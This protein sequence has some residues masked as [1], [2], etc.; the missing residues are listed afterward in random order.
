MPS[1]DFPAV[2]DLGQVTVVAPTH[3][4]DVGDRVVTAAERVPVV[5]LEPLARRASS[6]LFVLVAA[7]ASVPLVHGSLHRGRDLARRGGGLALRERLPRRLGPGET[8]GF[9]PLELLGDGLLDDRGQVAVGHRG[10]HEGPQSHELVVELG[11][12]R[13]LDPV[14]AWG[15]R[16]NPRG[17]RRAGG[18]GRAGSARTQIRA[19]GHS[20][21]TESGLTRPT[22]LKRSSGSARQLR[23]DGVGDR[24]KHLPPDAER[25]NQRPGRVGGPATSSRPGGRAASASPPEHPDG[26]NLRHEL[27]D[28]SLRAVGGPL[29]DVLPVR[30]GQ[31]RR[32]LCDG[33]QVQPP[34]GQQGQEEGMLSRGA[35]GGDPE[36]GLGLGEIGRRSATSRD[37]V[38][39]AP[40]GEPSLEEARRGGD[41]RGLSACRTRVLSRRSATARGGAAE[42]CQGE[43]ARRARR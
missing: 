18:R 8:P 42:T 12:G 4:G 2:V 26:A 33:R 16:R 30:Q 32:Q 15:Q 11:G 13:E 25:G 34:V 21:R 14:A 36:V 17:P 41:A 37:R 28:L 10:A 19:A 5:E 27:L 7:S 22:P 39:R 38:W 35:G 20:V 24:T 1:D 31:V 23:L 43:S 6:P 9:E 29:Q 40:C 3:Q